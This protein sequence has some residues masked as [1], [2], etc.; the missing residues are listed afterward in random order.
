MQ[1]LLLSLLATWNMI[2]PG[3]WDVLE[4]GKT[5]GWAF[6]FPYTASCL[7][8]WE[9]VPVTV[10]GDHP[11]PG[12]GS[13]DSIRVMTPL[14]A[15]VWASGRW[16]LDFSS[17]RVPDSSFE[18][19][20]GL[21]ENTGG[22]GRYAACLR[23]PVAGL[24]ALDMSM[25]REDTAGRQR[26]VLKHGELEAGGA[27]CRGDEN[28][29]AIWN[30]WTPGSSMVR[31][32]FA[33][34]HRGGRYWEA[35]AT[36]NA[37]I[38]ASR[39][40]AAAAFSLEDDTSGTFQGHLK[41]E[42]PL[43]GMMLIARG[44]VLHDDDPWKPG[45]TA[46][47]T[48]HPGFL[49]M[50]GGMVMP[51]GEDAGVFATVGA[52]PIDAFLFSATDSTSWGVEASSSGRLGRAGA[53]VFLTGDTLDFTGNFLPSVPWGEEGRIHG[54][55]SCNMRR[56]GDYLS[57]TLDIISVFTLESFAFIFA[58]ED[59]VDDLRSYSFGVTWAFEDNV[60][61]PEEREER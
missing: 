20:V 24:F 4:T 21:V 10:G 44:D 37:A 56:S 36:H 35:A 49:R 27:G 61:V 32:A 34:F 59:A 12:W 47:L 51:P 17:F 11:L 1:F 58:I 16:E 7:V 31:M 13:F 3:P 48:A 6:P 50:Q 33:H 57:G 54:G 23:R 29:Y 26:L 22:A 52:G 5:V 43:P 25:T 40:T 9:G 15:G 55:V 41:V 28:G 2:S 18:S 42:I 39:V 45:Y 19:A 46:G 60:P 53:G 30:A 8:T 38:G 14:D